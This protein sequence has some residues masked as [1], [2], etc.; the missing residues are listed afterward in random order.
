MIL[1]FLLFLFGIPILLAVLG[2]RPGFGLTFLLAAFFVAGYFS[3]RF[4]QPI[5]LL[6]PL[7]L[8]GMT[9]VAHLAEKNFREKVRKAEVSLEAIESEGNLLAEREKALAAQAPV[10]RRKLE[11]YAMLSE[12]TRL[13]SLPLTLDD[14]T[15]VIVRETSRMLDS[16]GRVRFLLMEEGGGELLKGDSFDRWVL[17][18]RRPLLV[19]DLRKD[20]RFS[21]EHSVGDIRSLMI[22]PLMTS[23]RTIGLLR[24]ESP[25]EASFTSEELR[26]L[27]TLGDLAASSVENVRLVQRMEHLG[28]VDELTGLYVHRHFQEVF[29]TLFSEAEARKHPLSVLLADIDHF[30]TYNDRYGHIAGD[31]VLKQVG[32]ILRE[33]SGEP[34]RVFRYGGEEFTL[35]LPDKAKEEALSIAEH[36]RQ[37]ISQRSFILRREKT[38]LSLSFG[39]AAFP[40]DGRTAEALLKQVDAF[41]YRAKREGRNRVC[42]A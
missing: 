1:F 12:F 20:F 10:L 28:R 8:A 40:E 36:L 2:G 24:I 37:K 39:V 22:A 15:G 25:Q 16:S 21:G 33:E 3:L 5:V 41:L 6:A 4:M 32:Q 42:G 31:L 9:G 19:G 11:R 23:Q 29:R 34:D 14:V 26:L 27:S 18:Q 17:K 38:H 13:L 35:L 7:G 30:K